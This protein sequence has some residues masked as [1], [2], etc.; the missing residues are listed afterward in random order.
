MVWLLSCSLYTHA[1]E[2]G[3]L[4]RYRLSLP[5]KKWALDITLLTIEI[6][7]SNFNLP[8]LSFPKQSFVSPIESFAENG[9][10]YLSAFE[11]GRKATDQLNLV[12]RV[13]PAL[14]PMVS[15]DFRDFALKKLRKGARGKK[16]WDYNQIPVAGYTT[17][18]IMAWFYAEYGWEPP[19]GTKLTSRNLEAYFVKDDVCAT[20]TLT[21]SSFDTD[22]EKLFYSLV[23]SV[24][25]VDVSN[26][27][28]SF[29]YYKIGLAFSAQKKYSRAAEAF[30]SALKLE[31]RQQELDP[32]QWRDLIMKAAEAH[33]ELSNATAA[34]EALEYGLSKEPRNT[35]FLMQL[36][37][38]YASQGDETKTLEI[39]EKALFYMNQEEPTGKRKFSDGTVEI[40]LPDL[41]N[42]PAFKQLMKNKSFREAVKA[43]KQ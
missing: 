38:T 41:K 2:T 43:M 22:D 15:S 14:R 35:F 40:R 29:D 13:Q 27:A 39:L 28:S 6:T 1:Q 19:E 5:E 21:A 30:D 12:I 31:Q 25:F 8:K 33:V 34:A 37:R 20:L 24:R 16:S 26:P 9:D 32:K 42:D 18:S 36:A 10:A 3:S 23:D 7:R 11:V 4:I 17:K